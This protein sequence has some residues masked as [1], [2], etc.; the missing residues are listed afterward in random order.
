MRSS[1]AWGFTMVYVTH[2]QAEAMTMA[3]Q[4]VLLNNGRIEQ[5]GTPRDLYSHPHSVFAGQF[6]G[7]PPMNIFSPN[8]LSG[9]SIGAAGA[10]DEGV[11]FGLRPEDIQIVQN[12]PLTGTLKTVEYFGADVLLTCEIAGE[13][14][15][16]RV[17]GQSDFTIGQT[18]SL[19]FEP[20][21]LSVFNAASG[22]RKSISFPP[23]GSIEN[24]ASLT[25]Q[26]AI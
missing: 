3:D 2:D 1:K 7:T 19:Q 18:L 6:I 14:V 25:Q 15:V 16:A 13:D 11:L 17:S 21:N 26:K 24:A 4:I 5:V 9:M 12:G 10:R 22:V 20:A 8:V 23:P